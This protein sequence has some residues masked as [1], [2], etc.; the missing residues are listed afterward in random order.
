[1]PKKNNFQGRG[2]VAGRPYFD[3]VPRRH[4]RNGQSDQVAFFKVLVDFPRDETQARDDTR[5]HDRIRVVAYGKLAEALRGKIKPGDWLYVEGYIQLRQ[6]SGNGAA[7]RES[8]FEI[9][10]L[11]YDHFMR[12]FVPDSPRMKRLER[13]AE[14]RGV[15]VR[16]LLTRMIDEQT[17]Q[18]EL[19]PQ[20]AG[21]SLG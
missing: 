15:P 16:D 2:E 1:M 5:T 17:K 8:V 3:M 13:L 21:V 14:E 10:M 7:D 18:L 4:P 9:V 12:P 19:E 20:L 11:E 6:R